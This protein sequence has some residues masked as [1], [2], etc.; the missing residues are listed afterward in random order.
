M[1]GLTVL[2][3]VRKPRHLRD[4]SELKLWCLTQPLFL[5][6][7]WELNIWE[8]TFDVEIK[9][10]IANPL[11]LIEKTDDWSRRFIDHGTGISSFSFLLVELNVVLWVKLLPSVGF[12]GT[13]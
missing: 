6:E 12:V 13:C 5:F 2:E 1:I 4:K 3:N 7:M 11:P 9:S 10:D 8:L